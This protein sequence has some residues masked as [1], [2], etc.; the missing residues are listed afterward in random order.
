MQ[1]MQCTTFH[2]PS[3]Q[4]LF[5][6]SRDGK[7]SYRDLKY[8]WEGLIKNLDFNFEHASQI[9]STISAI[10]NTEYDPVI[11]STI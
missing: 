1:Y 6:L 11:Q 7:S 4:W 3:V 5:L 9:L 8:L 2:I 10:R